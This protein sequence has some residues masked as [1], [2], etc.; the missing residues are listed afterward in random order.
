MKRIP[1]RR[2]RRRFSVMNTS[3]SSN[4]VWATT[5]F[6]IDPGN[7]LSNMIVMSTDRTARI[8]MG[9]FYVLPYIIMSILLLWVM[10]SAPKY[11]TIKMYNCD[12]LLEWLC[13]VS[14]YFSIFMKN[15]YDLGNDLTIVYEYF[16]VASKVSS[17]SERRA[18]QISA[19]FGLINL[20]QIPL[21]FLLSMF[22]AIFLS[23][24]LFLNLLLNVVALEFVTEIDDA[25]V[26]SF[27]R[28]RYSDHAELCVSVL[29]VRYAE[30]F[31]ED[32][33]LWHKSCS[34]KSRVLQ[35]L[36]EGELTNEMR[37][38]LL[39]STEKG[40]GLLG[41]V[42]HDKTHYRECVSALKINMGIIDWGCLSEEDVIN[43][44]SLY[45]EGTTH[46]TWEH[47]IGYQMRALL[48]QHYPEQTVQF[49]WFGLNLNE[50]DLTS[51]HASCI[52]KI[53][54]VH[55]ENVEMVSL[56]GSCSTTSAMLRDGSCSSTIGG[57]SVSASGFIQ[58]L[59]N[60][61]ETNTTLKNL[62]FSW[63]NLDDDC[64][65]RLA[66]FL[67]RN[68]SMETLWLVGNKNITDAGALAILSSLSSSY[69]DGDDDDNDDDGD[70]DD[71]RTSTAMRR[72]DSNKTL[73]MV[74]L[75]WN[76][77]SPECEEKCTEVEKYRMI[78]LSEKYP[79]VRSFLCRNNEESKEEMQNENEKKWN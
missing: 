75:G 21:S 19:F 29:D 44:G 3:L 14:I 42:K 1:S 34:S 61:L 63:C 17:T 71:D 49:P 35:L 22:I 47:F 79:D 33:D 10:R 77:I 20:V 52:A 8:V 78:F 67:R 7:Q 4:D 51:R 27:L 58:T 9:V 38:E 36:S 25:M 15:G 69:D 16:L 76:S 59:C 18:M 31:N 68:S 40:L 56:G 2:I 62:S 39:T 43:Y 24:D 70:G 57:S 53:C 12:S 11:M 6:E 55:G 72:S 66:S 30:H 48:F 13:V 45:L 28:R 41:S 60:G 74:V 23:E 65:E 64:A 46:R 32:I 37:W 73:Q 26:T 50:L 54:N 5:Q